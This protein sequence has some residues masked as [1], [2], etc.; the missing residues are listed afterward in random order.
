MSTLIGMDIGVRYTKIVELE[1]R[2]QAKGLLLNHFLFATPYL[3]QSQPGPKQIDAESFRDEIAKHIPL[4]RLKAA[5][6]GVNL[7]SSAVT[8]LTLLLPRVAKN[9]LAVV[10]QNEARRKMIPASTPEHIFE[11]SL[12]GVRIVAKIPRFEVLVLR[13][14]KLHVQQV[15]EL[16]KHIGATPSGITLAPCALFTLVPEEILQKQELDTAFVDIGLQSINTSI[17]REGRLSFFRNASYGLQDII[18]DLS[19]KLNLSEPEAETLI[20]EKGIVDV[21]FD[22][23]DKVAVAEEIMRQKYEASQKT[24]NTPQKAEANLLE[25]RLLWQAHIDRIMH[26]LRRS[27]SYYKE[28]SE[29]R[30][31]E[32]IYFL[33]GGCQVK[34]LVNL[35]TKHLGGQWE[36]MLPFRGVAAPQDGLAQDAR[37]TPIFSNACA[38]ALSLSLKDKGGDII[39]FLPFELKRKEALAARRLIILAVKSIL[40]SVFAAFSLA[41]FINSRSV[42]AAIKRMDSDLNEIKAV[43]DTLKNLS[44]RNEKIKAESAQ[45]QALLEGRAHLYAPLAQL[46]KATPQGVL[47]TRVVIAKAGIAAYPQAQVQEEPEAGAQAP[48]ALD[49]QAA[50]EAYAVT[51]TLSVEIGAEVFADYETAV[52]IVEQMRANLERSASL[53]KNIRAWPLELEKISPAV[54]AAGKTLT[55]TQ[56]MRRSFTITA[57]VAQ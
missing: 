20:K 41:A 29:G 18:Q 54:G 40:V 6:I 11:S 45:I 13:S 38:L 50:Q 1:R 10:A 32:Y 7:S 22:L 9:E 48:E 57:E 42:G 34:N 46:A 35:L 52:A 16:F 4:E 8:A 27:L 24:Q 21:D 14:E 25:L 12:V 51:N 3:A 31:I 43:A 30:R 26:E 44:L 33:G 2:P 28:Q 56:P 17:V 47:L 55:L 49:G 37:S 39:N 36:I 53:L 19:L 5:S 23:K 15:L